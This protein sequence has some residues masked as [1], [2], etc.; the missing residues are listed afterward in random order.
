VVETPIGKPEGQEN[1]L[2]FGCLWYGSTYL[3]LSPKSTANKLIVV[4]TLFPF[5]L[6]TVYKEPMPR[7]WRPFRLDFEKVTAID[8]Y[9]RLSITA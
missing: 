6:P 1:Q 2:R 9:Y 8:D 7:K 3:T 4:K 5:P